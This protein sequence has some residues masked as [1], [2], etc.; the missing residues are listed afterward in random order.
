[1]CFSRN[2][3]VFYTNTVQS[4][5]LIT[6]SKVLFTKTIRKAS[7]RNPVSSTISFLGALLCCLMSVYKGKWMLTPRYWRRLTTFSTARSENTE[8][9]RLFARATCAFSYLH[10]HCSSKERNNISW[11]RLDVAPCSLVGTYECFGE[12]CLYLYSSTLNV[13]QPGS[14]ETPEY[15]YHTTEHNIRHNCHWNNLRSL[16]IT[17]F[18]VFFSYPS[19]CNVLMNRQDTE[20]GTY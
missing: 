20:F 3:I 5:T 10:M 16:N 19:V 12:T 17:V 1:M 18:W 8:P 2:V 4:Q 7:I 13:D 14:A 11:C 9:Q 15:I 6:S